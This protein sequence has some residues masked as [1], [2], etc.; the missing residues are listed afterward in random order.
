MIWAYL[1][2]GISIGTILGGAAAGYAAHKDA[3]IKGMAMQIQTY[4]AG[5]DCYECEFMRQEDGGCRLR[6]PVGWKID[7]GDD[8]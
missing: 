1:A 8:E 5:I 2:I 6:T 3:T 7:E 4:C